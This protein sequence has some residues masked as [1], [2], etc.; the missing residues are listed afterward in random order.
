MWRVQC[1]AYF[2]SFLLHL[3]ILH[4]HFTFANSYLNC[5]IQKRQECLGEGKSRP[6]CRVECGSSICSAATLRAVLFYSCTK[7]IFY[8]D[9]HTH[10]LWPPLH[11]QHHRNSNFLLLHW[12]LWHQ[13]L[14]LVILVTQYV[15][16]LLNL[17]APQVL[18]VHI[19]NNLLFTYWSAFPDNTLSHDIIII[20]FISEI[21]WVFKIWIK[22]FILS[23]PS[24]NCLISLV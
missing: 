11:S 24:F 9:V 7:H 6:V 4:A 14:C 15:N 22:H 2:S 13:T 10:Q 16:H 12:I 21:R 18:C 8:F 1:L 17:L 3:V 5:I 19:F 20:H 23:S